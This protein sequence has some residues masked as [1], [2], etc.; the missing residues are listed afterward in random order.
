MKSDKSS[1]RNVTK[2]LLRDYTSKRLCFQSSPG[3]HGGGALVGDVAPD[4]TTASENVTTAEAEFLADPLDPRVAFSP[5]RARRWLDSI[6]HD[7]DAEQVW[8]VNEVKWR[9]QEAVRIGERVIRR[10]GPSL[11]LGF[12]PDP[13]VFGN[14]DDFDK[15]CRYEGARDGSRE[16]DELLRAVSRSASEVE[17]SR[18][19]Q[20]IM[21]P[22]HYLGDD[23]FQ[24]ERMVLQS[25]LKSLAFHQP[26]KRWMVEPESASRRLRGNAFVVITCGLIRDKA[27]VI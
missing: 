20:A 27:R 9:L 10:D 23:R 26:W 2:S 4:V 1:A 15:N 7:R 16:A 18:F 17:V 25:W 21:W 24:S 5:A 3:A 8:T 11:S 14:V 6:R 19:E 12:W 13:N 22:L